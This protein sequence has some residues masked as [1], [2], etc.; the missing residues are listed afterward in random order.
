MSDQALLARKKLQQV[1]NN[2]NKQREL[3]NFLL[4]T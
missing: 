2:Y 4:V 3:M 1:K